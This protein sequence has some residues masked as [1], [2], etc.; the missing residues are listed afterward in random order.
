MLYPDLHDICNQ[1]GFRRRGSAYFRL[2]GDGVLQVV[3]PKYERGLYGHIL[4][5][6]LF[7]MYGDL[8]RQ[9]FTSS[10]C[11]PRYS[12]MNCAAQNEIPVVYAPPIC[13][14]IELFR[15]PVLDWLNSIDTQK[16][17]SIAIRKLDSTW[18]DAMKIAPYLACAEI[19]HAKKVVNEIVKQH[20]YANYFN[21]ALFDTNRHQEDENEDQQLFVLLQMIDRADTVE[22]DKYLKNN[23][24]RN[25]EYA[26]FCIK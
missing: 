10:G 25:I 24:V 16:K 4:Y 21:S 5:V 8:L 22:I 3:K 2:V 17:L 7:S 18:N 12:V 23:Y 26:G 20:T 14:Q 1:A 13:D 11:I 9:W 19:N 6:G 15:D